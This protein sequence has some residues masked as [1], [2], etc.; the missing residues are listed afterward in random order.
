MTQCPPYSW[1]QNGFAVVKAIMLGTLPKSPGE[2]K[3]PLN[4]WSV[5]EMCWQADC[6][7]RG[8]GNVALTA[9]TA[10]ITG[11]ER[12]NDPQETSS[13]LDV[14]RVH[15]PGATSDAVIVTKDLIAPVERDDP[16]LERKGMGGGHS[17]ETGCLNVDA[18]TADN[19]QN[20]QLKSPLGF[21]HVTVATNV[22]DVSPSGLETTLRRIQR[23]EHSTLQQILIDAVGVTRELGGNREGLGG[24]EPGNR[25]A[26]QTRADGDPDH[27]TSLS[28]LVDI[29]AT[30]FRESGERAD[31]DVVDESYQETLN[32]QTPG[33]RGL[34]ETVIDHSGVIQDN[35]GQS[36]SHQDVDLSVAHDD[37]ALQPQPVGQLGHAHSHR[38]LVGSIRERFTQRKGRRDHN[39]SITHNKEALQLQP[40]AH[41]NRAQSL[42]ELACEMVERYKQTESRADLDLSITYNEEALGLRA[43]GGIPIVHRLLTSSPTAPWNATS[44]VRFEP[45][46][47]SPS[48]TTRRPCNLES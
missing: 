24:A 3:S 39:L 21:T 23:S 33:H 38:S 29:F 34:V 47:T 45:I 28:R 9:L 1:I 19:E 37:E 8:T 18:S 41:L 7:K 2:L 15:I 17:T 44:T 46:S 42:H 4:L 20:H 13:T 10:L 26:R 31:I 30:Q 48:S 35:F 12:S 11:E 36:K 22:E 27:S 25:T 40:T 14:T 6:E 43:G 16:R 5:I 32:L